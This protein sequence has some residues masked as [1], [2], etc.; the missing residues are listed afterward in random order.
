MLPVILRIPFDNYSFLLRKLRDHHVVMDSTLNKA[1][2]KEC[3][4]YKGA[5]T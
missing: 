2:W 1:E 5:N 3:N 4:V